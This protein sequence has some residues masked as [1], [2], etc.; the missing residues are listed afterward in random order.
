MEEPRSARELSLASVARACLFTL[1][2]VVLV[3][4]AWECDDAYL[5][6]RTVWNWFH[7]YGLR[8]NVVERV[9]AYTHPLWMLA[10][11][12]CYAVTG[13][14]YFS[15]LGL[16]IALSLVSATLLARSAPS[17]GLA[18]VL[19]AL[20]V[21]SAATIDYCVSG[22]ETP[23][24]VLLLC[25]FVREARATE[26][27]TL[28]LCTIAS[29]I[30]LTRLDALV[31]VLPALVVACWGQPLRATLRS[32]ALGALPL[33]LWHLFS[34]A[35]YGFVFPNTAYAKLNLH[36][37]LGDVLVRGEIYLWD[38]LRHDPVT[39]LATFAAFHAALSR[40]KGIDR[41][42][43]WGIILYVAYVLRIGGDFMSG[44]FFVA[45]FVTAL[46]L[47]ALY[48]LFERERVSLALG[49][50]VLVLS[51]ILPRSRLLSGASYG[52]TNV[53]E[54][55]V[56]ETGIADERAYYYPS[57]GLLAVWPRLPELSAEGLPV[58]PYRGAI[59]GGEVAARGVRVQPVKEVGFFGYFAG[60]DVY[61]LDRF[62]LGDPL[63][64]R[65]PFEPGEGFRVGH[66]ERKIP[67]GYARSVV[68]DN[69]IEDPAVHDFDDALRLVTRGP[70]WSAS[71]WRS[72]VR[73]NLGLPPRPPSAGYL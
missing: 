27:R 66:Y 62:A 72:L 4:C 51:A 68:R 39:L 71:R 33:A 54:D 24:L 36:V 19:L 1:L 58:P 53:P 23:L 2:L 55:N 42:L 22:L 17:Q 26:R 20:F 49:A 6:F 40:G 47:L 60:P 52:A 8:W 11:A 7:G 65:L 21:S 29:L 59:S 61:V 31:I 50:A 25:L 73:M 28:V 32:V 3:R 46:P 9:Q 44:R 34:L 5:T 41:A 16:S 18:V 38:S 10:S 48:P 13:E 56:R 67:A 69:E 37:P 63:L 64:A 15:I 45:P 30:G 35:Y 43:G 57:T 70:L 14:L 12:A